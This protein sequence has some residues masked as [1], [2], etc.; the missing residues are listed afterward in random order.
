MRLTSNAPIVHHAYFRVGCKEHNAHTMHTWSYDDTCWL[1][2]Q[3]LKRQLERNG[4]N[5]KVFRWKGPVVLPPDP[6]P[7]QMNLDDLPW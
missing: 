2:L 6:E 3:M 5:V 1:M 7:G 4:F